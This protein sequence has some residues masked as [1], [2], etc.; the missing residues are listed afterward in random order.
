MVML[1]TAKANNQI[2]LV[3][4]ILKETVASAAIRPMAGFASK[5]RLFVVVI[6][7]AFEAFIC[8]LSSGVSSGYVQVRPEG[9]QGIAGFWGEILWACQSSQRA[10]SGAGRVI[11]E[12]I[13]RS[14]RVSC[15]LGSPA[16]GVGG[17]YC[18]TGVS[19]S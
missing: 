18:A 5:L 14:F 15:A 19:G 6:L 4:K 12:G 10:I 13:E 11:S 2:V 9:D 3:L 16:L 17:G 7:F 8:C 1:A